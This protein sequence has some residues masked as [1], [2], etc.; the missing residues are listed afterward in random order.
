MLA[1]FL[2][3]GADQAGGSWSAG[4]PLPGHEERQRP[5]ASRSDFSEAISHQ[6]IST[7]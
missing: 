6:S 5:L 4:A 1:L 3:Q 7:I 2:D